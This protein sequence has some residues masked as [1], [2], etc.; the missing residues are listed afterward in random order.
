MC[1]YLLMRKYL[2]LSFLFL[3]SVTP[4]IAWGPS[5]L[6]D[7]QIPQ[8]AVDQISDTQAGSTA[9]PTA[10]G[11]R[12]T[13]SVVPTRKPSAL[14]SATQN[15]NQTMAPGQENENQDV[16]K[17]HR[18]IIKSVDKVS[19]QV[20]ELINTVGAKGGIGEQVR[21]I[22]QNQTQIQQEIKSDL[23]KINSRSTIAK[24]LVGG[25][26]KLTQSLAQKLNQNNLM[27]ENL[28][29]LKLETKNQSDL[30][31]LQETIDLM[32][33]QNTSL[34]NKISLE[35]K[36]RGIFSWITNLFVK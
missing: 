8:K 6:P 5:N 4:I 14:P 36:T 16:G 21:E 3:L 12:H 27:I 17:P 33:Y 10:T 25:D 9:K 11:N 32:V 13:I 7:S 23:E 31:Q 24:F 34:Q 29:Q 22:A 28:E 26:K 2:V 1:Y 30:S 18:E 20:L 35:N 19:T 15:K